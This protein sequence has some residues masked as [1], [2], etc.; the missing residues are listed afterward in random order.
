MYFPVPSLNP[1]ESM[2]TALAAVVRW[3]RIIAGPSASFIIF[4][5]H[6]GILAL[7]AVTAGVT[8]KL[9]PLTI[10]TLL[11]RFCAAN[12]VEANRLASARSNYVPINLAHLRK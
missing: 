10:L 7:D 6:R 11:A 8:R 2:L 5:L 3:F 9:P 1:S 12:Q 4:R